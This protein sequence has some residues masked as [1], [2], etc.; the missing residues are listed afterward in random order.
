M[1]DEFTFGDFSVNQ[2]PEFG[3]RTSL[4]N[5]SGWAHS[6]PWFGMGLFDAIEDH[7]P[8]NQEALDFAANIKYQDAMAR[9]P[10]FQVTLPE[11]EK[12]GK[13]SNYKLL[14]QGVFPYFNP[15]LID[16]NPSVGLDYMRKLFGGIGRLG[17]RKNLEDER[18]NI[19]LDYLRSF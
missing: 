18:G 8:F 9:D 1:A 2:E 14:P 4:D 3:Y 7:D 15:S 12:L 10:N 6:D 19:Y 13:F 16:N 11:N 17:F 5:P